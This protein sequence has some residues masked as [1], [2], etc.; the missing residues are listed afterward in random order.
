MPRE[1]N[2]QLKPRN[3]LLAWVGHE[4]LLVVEVGLNGLAGRPPLHQDVGALPRLAAP[5]EVE[6]LALLGL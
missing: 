2:E 4:P 5:D 6:R 1:I 3:A